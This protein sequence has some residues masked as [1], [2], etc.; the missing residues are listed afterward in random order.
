MGHWRKQ[1]ISFFVTSN[2]NLGCVYCYIPKLGKTIAPEDRVID[3]EFAVAG[4][5]DFFSWSKVPRI[6]YFSA[7]EATTAFDTMVAIRKEAHKIV[8]D[9][10]EVELQTNG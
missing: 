3:M 1:E 6:R 7:G 2:C 10:L 5:K 4:M 9:N 8:G